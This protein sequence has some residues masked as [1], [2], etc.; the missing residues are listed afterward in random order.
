MGRIKDEE[1]ILLLEQ[2]A[3]TPA[4]KLAEQLGVTETAVRKRIQKLEEQQII[5]QHTIRI[6]PKKSNFHIVFVGV[7]TKPETYMRVSQTLLT[8][9]EVKRMYATS[10]DHHLQLECWFENKESF[11]NFIQ[12]L[13]KN[14]DTRK[15]CPGIIQ[16]QLK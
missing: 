11:N 6:S 8:R 3:R 2:N 9:N 7:D 10:G 1:L 4:T 13:E 16:E 14:P 12:E 5:T 15:V